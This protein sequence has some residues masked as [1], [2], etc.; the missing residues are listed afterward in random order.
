MK[1]WLGFSMAVVLAGSTFAC[2]SRDNGTG[3]DAGTTPGTDSGMTTGT[4]AGMTTG[5]AI[6][7]A[8][9]VA[10][11]SSYKNI[12]V[13]IN[14]AVV[15]AA[16]SYTA[17]TGN[18]AGTFYI[19]DQTGGAGLGVYH[20]SKD[21]T[22]FPAIGDVVSVTGRLSSFNGSLQISAST[23]YNI[24]LTVTK[25]GTGT[26][27]SGAYP[28]AGMPTA[29]ANPSEYAHTK[30]GAH[31]EQIGTALKFAGPVTVTPGVPSGF[32]STPSNADGGA[33]KP[34]GFA[35]TGD[36]WVDDSIVYHDCIK[37]LDGGT[38][39]LNL[40]NGISGVWDRYQDYNAGSAS[41]PAPTV[42]VLVPTSCKDLGQ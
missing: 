18:M 12:P 22:T 3:T 39:A 11:A 1:T 2:S 25:T 37:P 31:P 42:P 7:V 14:N 9:A 26:A 8:T 30:T 32:V 41:S 13:Q 34:E 5:T 15:I 17:T 19:Q 33:P 29:V 20:G 40:S 16:Y 4:D 24:P 10:S 28:P 21:T 27:M 35:V 23:K 36:I 6:T 38:A